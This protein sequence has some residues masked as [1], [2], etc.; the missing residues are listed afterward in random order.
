M[1]GMVFVEDFLKE[2]PL[3]TKLRT[4]M[5]AKMLP[6]AL[7]ARAYAHR[8]GPGRSGDRHLLERQHGRPQGRDA[9]PSQHPVEHRRF[10]AGVQAHRDGRDDRRP[11]V[12]PRLRLHRH[13]VAAAGERLRRR[14]PSQPDGRQDDR[15]HRRD[16]TAARSSSARRRSTRRTSARSSPTSSRTCATRSSARRSSGRRSP[17]RSRIGSGSICIEGYGCTEMAPVVAVNM[18]ESR[19]RGSVGRP[20]PGRERARRRSGDRRRAARR[21]GRDAAGQRA[22]TGC[23]ATS[24]TPTLTATV[25]HDG[26]YVDRRHRDDRRRRLHPHH[27]PA[28]RGSARSPARWCRT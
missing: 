23:A 13:A 16:S 15:R 2:I 6:A 4:A 7:I 25:F 10:D 19:G 26:W 12:L 27:R 3:A 21:R 24:T 11:A 17:P 1:D 22:R 28:C 14:V 8:I 18:P 5:A 9:H 20:I